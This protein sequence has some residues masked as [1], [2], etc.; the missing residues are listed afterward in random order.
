MLLVA[1]CR[2]LAFDDSL[3][4]WPRLLGPMAFDGIGSGARH[5][6][7]CDKVMVQPER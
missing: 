7:A 6:D 5:C 3:L 1:G 2:V 4:R